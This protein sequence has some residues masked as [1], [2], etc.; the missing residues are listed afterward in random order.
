MGFKEDFMPESFDFQED[1]FEDFLLNFSAGF[2]TNFV[3]F[4]YL[5]STELVIDFS[6]VGVNHIF[7]LYLAYSG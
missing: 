1:F 3:G 2:L 7:A 5:V 6:F 4:Q